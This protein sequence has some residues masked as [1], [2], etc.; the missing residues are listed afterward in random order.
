MNFD[1]NFST[2]KNEAKLKIK[3]LSHLNNSDRV[4]TE[5][6]MNRRFL[7][8]EY[9]FQQIDNESPRVSLFLMNEIKLNK[10]SENDFSHDKGKG[11]LIKYWVQISDK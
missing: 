1:C 7:D 10:I 4:K 11:F 2:L 6:R 5:Y 3:L 8:F 9:R